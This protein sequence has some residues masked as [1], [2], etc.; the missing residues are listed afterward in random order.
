MGAERRQYAQLSR[1]R[2]DRRAWGAAIPVTA[3]RERDASRRWS[4]RGVRVG[5]RRPRGGRT[6]TQSRAGPGD[7]DGSDGP[8]GFLAR[9]GAV[10]ARA[11]L[12]RGRLT[13]SRGRPR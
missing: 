12:E 3:K 13:S 9:V 10:P 1:L 2:A 6:R 8:A 7:S 4:R 5:R 11:G